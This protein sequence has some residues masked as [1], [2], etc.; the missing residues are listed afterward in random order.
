[1]GYQ[2][3]EREVD[4]ETEMNPMFVHIQTLT[5]GQVFVSIKCK[6]L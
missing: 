4:T 3:S 5:K 6:L 2:R 1:M